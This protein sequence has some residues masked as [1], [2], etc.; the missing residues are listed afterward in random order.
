MVILYL[1]CE[2]CKA[3]ILSPWA[4]KSSVLKSEVVVLR[5][6]YR[7]WNEISSTGKRWCIFSKMDVWGN[8]MNLIAFWQ[9]QFLSIEDKIGFATKLG[10]GQKTPF[11]LLCQI[12]SESIVVNPLPIF[13]VFYCGPLAVWGDI[14]KEWVCLWAL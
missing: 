11:W 6:L 12:H 13:S 1:Q 7:Q 4:L 5:P 14:S 9:C 2:I 3:G 8:Y 10:T